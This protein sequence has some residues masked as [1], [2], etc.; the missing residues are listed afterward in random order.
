VKARCK[1]YEESANFKEEHMKELPEAQKSLNE[2]QER[3]KFLEEKF[4]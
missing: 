3:T 4:H 1:L 2:L